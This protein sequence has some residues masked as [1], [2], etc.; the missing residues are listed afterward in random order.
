MNTI[1][2]IIFGIIVLIGGIVA[3]ALIRHTADNL[4]GKIFCHGYLS[5][6]II[7]G[8]MLLISSIYVDNSVPIF[9]NNCGCLL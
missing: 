2:L 3:W 9:Y 8:G 6:V 4:F 1:A 5:L 7:F